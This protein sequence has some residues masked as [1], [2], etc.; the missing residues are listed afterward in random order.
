MRTITSLSILFNALLLQVWETGAQVN[1]G[2]DSLSISG[3]GS[4]L[5][6]MLPSEGTGIPEGALLRWPCWAGRNLSAKP[7]KSA[8]NLISSKGALKSQWRARG[9][10]TLNTYQINQP[11]VW[12]LSHSS[13][14]LCSGA[15]SILI[16][17]ASPFSLP[18]LHPTVIHWPAYFSQVLPRCPS[19][20]AAD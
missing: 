20:N 17:I 10:E 7:G 13:Y 9:L 3:P 18:P 19:P 4:F 16:F 15:I 12:K 5:K 14:R 1:F 8:Y 2:V 11:R 6:A